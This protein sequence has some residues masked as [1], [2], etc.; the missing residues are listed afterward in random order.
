MAEVR[1][2]RY[3][4]ENNLLPM[5]CMRCGRPATLRKQK[6]FNWYPSWVPL[7]IFAGFLPYVILVRVLGKKMRVLAPLCE[8]HRFHWMWITLVVPLS[9][10]FLFIFSCGGLLIIDITVGGTAV[11]N[12][13]PIFG[14]GMVFGF[15]SWIIGAIVVNDTT[16]HPTEITENSIT[17]IR[18]SD[19]FADAVSRERHA[20]P[21]ADQPRPQPRGPQSG[22]EQFYSPRG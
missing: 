3:E 20:A 14:I 5:V 21:P 12:N 9:L 1:L 2:G 16:I 11:D 10:L 15:L 13:M 18:V 7:L 19:A 6:V 22:G 4:A 8:S 17:L